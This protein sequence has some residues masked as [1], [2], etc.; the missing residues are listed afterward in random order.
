[1][2]IHPQSSGTVSAASG[3][4]PFDCLP[5]LRYARL[6]QSRR[7]VTL[8]FTAVV[9]RENLNARTF[10]ISADRLTWTSVD[11]V[12]MPVGNDESTVAYLELPFRLATGTSYTL[13][14]FTAG[15]PEDWPL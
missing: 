15:E 2:S 11:A 7:G 9:A 14:V 8:G 10:T 4:P 12:F 6:W 1:M 3:Q 13:R 5:R